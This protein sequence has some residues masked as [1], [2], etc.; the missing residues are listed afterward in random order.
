M[1]IRDEKTYAKMSFKD[2]IV[3]F[4]RAK[5]GELKLAA[6]RAYKA[7]R[8]ILQCLAMVHDLHRKD[9]P[10]AVP[11]KEML[12]VAEELENKYPKIKE[13]TQMALNLFD[14]WKNDNPKYEDIVILL[15]SLNYEWI[16]Q[17][18]TNEEINKIKNMY[19]NL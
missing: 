9:T 14:E 16:N 1:H 6:F 3:A 17:F 4:E 2:F 19:R 5:K 8:R 18:L 15:K 12:K 10:C 7:E 13:M 11:K